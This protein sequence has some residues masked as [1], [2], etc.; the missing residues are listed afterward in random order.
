MSSHQ[1]WSARNAQQ[2]YDD[3]PPPRHSREYY[4]QPE[5]YDEAEYY[6]QPQ[7]TVTGK[8]HS[9]TLNR[10][11]K[12]PAI[13]HETKKETKWRNKTERDKAALVSEFLELNL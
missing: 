8:G 3:Q 13:N 9:L 11:N 7:T 4:D 5:Y 10:G 6:D 12:R 1:H 2:H